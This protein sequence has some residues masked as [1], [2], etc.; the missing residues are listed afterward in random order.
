MVQGSGIMGQ[1]TDRRN[2]NNITN[3][4]TECGED[5]K[6]DEWTNYEKRICINCGS[7]NDNEPPEEWTEEAK[8]GAKIAESIGLSLDDLDDSGDMAEQLR[9]IM[10][11]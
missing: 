11:D 1:L 2:M 7:D 4:C 10:Q 5:A 6:Y 8:E 9:R 3:T